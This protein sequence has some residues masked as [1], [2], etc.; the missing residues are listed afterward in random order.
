MTMA[1]IVLQFAKSIGGFLAAGSNLKRARNQD[2]ATL[3]DGMAACLK[4]IADE[5]EAGK[6]PVA[7]CHELL[8]YAQVA[9]RALRKSAGFWNGKS[10][11][12]LSGAIEAAVD[13]PSTAVF[14]LRE[15][16]TVAAQVF[17]YGN[18]LPAVNS[19]F[20]DEMRKLREAQGLLSAAANLVRTGAG[21]PQ[22]ASP[23][24]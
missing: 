14:A 8:H 4:T 23:A 3:L 1:E 13:A 2:M 10:V 20:E 15:R 5:L 7:Q 9:P 11:R 6:E 21:W 24:R 12:L 19:T 16:R 17:G 18:T 22:P